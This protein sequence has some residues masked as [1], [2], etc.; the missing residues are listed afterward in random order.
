MS[1]K[2]FKYK[3]GV[4]KE[5]YEKFIAAGMVI[6]C[7]DEGAPFGDDDDEDYATV[8]LLLPG[9]NEVCG[10]CQGDG[11][12]TNRNIDGNGITQSEWSEWDYEDRETYMNGGYDVVC[13]ECHGNKIS[14][15]LD[16]N[17]CPDVVKEH[18]QSGDLENYDAP[19]PDDEAERKY[20]A[21]WG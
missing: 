5:M 9:K 12:H 18:M 20:F 10:E 6:D 1:A 3:T 8:T 7:D 14:F 4:S 11:Q 16:Y 2:P 13:T 19:D 17:A 21:A 15:Q